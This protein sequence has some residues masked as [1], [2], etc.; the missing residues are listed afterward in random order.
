MATDIA[1]SFP[2]LHSNLLR[3]L[4]FLFKNLWISDNRMW[5]YLTTF[6]F[7][8]SNSKKKLF[9]FRFAI[10]I[11]I[12]PFQKTHL[13]FRKNIFSTWRSKIWIVLAKKIVINILNPW[14]ISMRFFGR[15]FIFA[16][17]FTYNFSRYSFI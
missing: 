1:T 16:I 15:N 8:G 11:T 7:L 9:Y 4:H 17:L 13:W 5:Q 3:I 6:I 10:Q 14:G 2:P 12:A